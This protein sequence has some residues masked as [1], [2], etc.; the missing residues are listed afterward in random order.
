MLEF[1]IAT[2]IL[3]ITI[4]IGFPIAYSI[5]ITTV[6]YILITNPGNLLVVPIRMFSGINSFTLMALPL[7]MLAAEI[8]VRTGIST[9]LF[10]FVRITKVGKVRG[11]L[12]FVNI[13]ASTIFGSI[14][15]A[16]LSDIAGLGK[17]EMEAMDEDGYPHAF[18][19]AITAASSTESPL[20]PPSNIAILYAGTMSL[21][22]GAVLYAG[23]IPGLVLALAQIVYVALNAK[24]LNLP[25]HEKVYSKEE[26]KN[27]RV[28]GWIAMGFPLIILLGITLGWFTPTEAA[29]VAVLYALVVGVLIFRNINGKMLLDALWAAGKTTANLFVITS[30]SAVFAWAIGIEQIPQKLAAALM[31]LSD[32]VYIILFVINIILVIVGMWMETSAAVLL[33][34]PILAPIAV[35]MGVHPVHFAVVMILNLTVGLV[36][37]PVGVVLYATADVGK[38]KFEELVK[39]IIPFVLISFVVLALVTF[40]PDISLFVPRLLGFID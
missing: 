34:A 1:W 18:S 37:P 27:I 11:G 36:T 10:D 16:A 28:S 40:I 12:A 9:K 17:V 22:V 32:N 6:V 35:R 20:I 24:R 3:I 25:K 33:F 8:M 29:A 23:F 5:G 39:A 38:I 19:A 21:S 14:S 31:S 13:I 26:K 7:F 15:G 4:L 2:A 30:I